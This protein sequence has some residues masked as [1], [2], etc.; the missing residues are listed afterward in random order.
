MGIRTRRYIGGRNAEVPVPDLKR[1]AFK[2]VR[3][4]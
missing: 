1:D 3:V 4:S 2:S